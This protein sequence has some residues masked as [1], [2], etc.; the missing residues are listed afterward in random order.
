MPIHFD[1]FLQLGRQLRDLRNSKDDKNP[2]CEGDGVASESSSSACSERWFLDRLDLGQREHFRDWLLVNS[3]CRRFRAWGKK[4]FFSEK[5]FIARPRFLK[6]IC[7]QMAKNMSAQNV[8]VARGCIHHVI[9][10]LGN[11]CLGNARLGNSR[12][13][14]A[15][16]VCSIATLPVYDALP[17]LR[18]L[19]LLCSCSEA[20]ILPRLNSAPLKRYPL[21]EKLSRL[22]RNCGLPVDQLQVDILS[23]EDGREDQAEMSHPIRKGYHSLELLS[24]IQA[25]RANMANPLGS[26]SGA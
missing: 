20:D 2:I 26:Q 23:N 8:A 15:R 10:P 14:N 13:G 9:A 16:A 3:T 18:S 1:L 4:A 19:S 12:L 6:R 17:Y 11:A 24:Q 25:H 7:E 21:S 5:I 22:L